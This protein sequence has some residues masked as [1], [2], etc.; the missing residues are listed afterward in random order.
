[1]NMSDA[2]LMSEPEGAK[3]GKGERLPMCFMDI[4]TRLENWGACQRGRSGG[5]M[6]S[7]ETRQTSPYGGQGYKCMTDVVCNIMRLAAH[8]PV[9]GA[10]TQAKF[11]FGDS[12]TVNAAWQKCE[13]RHSLILKYYY[14]YS[15][16]DFVICRE[17]DIKQWPATH[18][19]RELL[20]AQLAIQKLIDAAR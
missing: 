7:K 12:E 17:L 16:P 2:V 20:A 3:A 4:A 19:K 6:A 5:K 13:V 11:D 1:M 8:G 18:F 10:S 9:G 14:V 15:K